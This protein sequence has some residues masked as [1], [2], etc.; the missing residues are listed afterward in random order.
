MPERLSDAIARGEEAVRLGPDSVDAHANLAG[1][2]AQ[3][4]RWEAAVEQL[5]IAVRLNPASSA[6]RDNLGKLKARRGQ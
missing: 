5:E 4:G 2:Y 6:I 1:V 3:T